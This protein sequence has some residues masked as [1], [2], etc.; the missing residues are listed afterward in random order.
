M[1]E[2]GQVTGTHGLNGVIQVYSHTRPAIGI[3]GYSYWWIGKNTHACRRFHVVRCWQHGKRILACLSGIDTVEDA[4]AL[5]GW[6]IWVSREDVPVDNDEYLWC[7]LIGCSVADAKRGLLGKVVR[8]EEYGA[9]DILIV[10]TP[11]DAGEQGEWMI[12]FTQQII[13]KVDL[14]AKRIEVCLPPGMEACF[15]SRY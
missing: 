7:D 5:R 4:E 13:G 12:P 10:R 9:Q 15:T 2:V 6:K 14:S 1:L 8:L 3:A 11:P